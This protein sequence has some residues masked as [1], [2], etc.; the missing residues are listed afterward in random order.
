MSRFRVDS[1]NDINFLYRRHRDSLRQ[2]VS[3]AFGT[4]PPEPDDVVQAVFERYASKKGHEA[5]A[6]PHSFLLRSARNYVIDERRR[7]AVR[8]SFARDATFTAH[9][10]DELSAERVLSAR[11]RLTAVEQ[12]IA[13]LDPRSRDFLLMNRVDGLSCAKIARQNGCS[14]TLVKAI[15]AKALVECSNALL[16][17]EN[18][19]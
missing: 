9:P 18:L 6:N 19:T 7:Q 3:R 5:I 12:A 2:Y 8:S 13:K 14:A 4:G 15:I 10:G 1:E 16:E 17:D 11:Q